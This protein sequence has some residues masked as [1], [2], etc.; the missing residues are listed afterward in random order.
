[1]N[2]KAI[3]FIVLTVS[4]AFILLL[5]SA[6]ILNKH[7]DKLL[8]MQVEVSQNLSLSKDVSLKLHNSFRSIYVNYD[9]LLAT[10]K[11][12]K[13]DIERI[14]RKNFNY[15]DIKN[16]HT[17]A[18]AQDDHIQMIKRTNSIITN[19]LQFLKH[20]HMSNPLYFTRIT[21]EL[22][23]LSYE[24]KL[25]DYSFL[26]FYAIKIKEFELLEVKRQ[27]LQVYRKKFLI[28]AKMIL[29]NTKILK[30]RLDSFNQHQ[31]LLESVYTNISTK[32]SQEN[33]SIKNKMKVIQSILVILL[34][35][36][37]FLISKFLK[38]E[39]NHKIEEEKLQKI[40]DKNVIMSIIDLQGITKTIS[41]AH[42]ELTG[43]EDNEL[44]NKPNYM[45]TH[46]PKAEEI[47]K[48]LESGRS[49]SG[50][51][52]D[53]K[54]NGEEYWVSSV[55][56]PIYDEHNKIK[57]YLGIRHDI[58]NT[59][60]LEKV[61]QN[62]ENIIKSQTQIANNERDKALKASQSKSEFLANMSHEIRTPLNTINGFIEL[63]QEDEKDIKKQDYL[64]IVKNSSHNLLSIINDIL[65]FSKIESGHLVIDTIDFDPKKEFDILVK[66]FEG[67]FLEKNIDF[68]I[69]FE[70]LPK[71]INGD[72]LRIQQVITN[73]L[74]NAYK[75]TSKNK[76]VYLRISYQNS[77]LNVMVR[78]E[79]VGI[80]TEYQKNIFE[81]F[82]QEDSSTTRKYGGT[83]LGLSISYNLALLMNGTLRV[84]SKI[85]EGS[86]FY[87]SVPLDSNNN[88]IEKEVIREKC[89][90]KGTVLLVE[91]NKANQMFMKVILKKFGLNFD[92]ANNGLE[93]VVMFK[94]RRYD[95]ILMDENMPNM[96]G[97]E[98]TQLIL[99]YEKSEKLVH[100]PIIALTANSLVGDK[101]RFLEAGMDEYLSKP[102]DKNTLQIFLEKYLEKK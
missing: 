97:L 17:I 91:D 39:K 96:S 66:T 46:S 22:L 68:I 12:F 43:Y 54:K 45:L 93:A 51:I 31:F 44:I 35:I 87:F 73:L 3:K 74:S 58:T 48:I 41:S 37:V 80:S 64:N 61:T 56:E 92:I 63:L 52:S 34:F 84:E 57:Y 23:D 7:A 6:I 83:G 88:Q 75:F 98:A 13:N 42:K 70:N 59:V 99:N 26:D 30:G 11:I 47:R 27:N 53:K 55:V 65:D 86:T 95:L 90:F 15:L 85:N 18:I 77:Y 1:M 8:S 24:I 2:T 40:I 50:Q 28:H 36:F 102:L 78:D 4:I 101:A 20:Y 14:T 94:E 60:R 100:T 29:K 49:W 72:I 69:S 5:F 33:H 81:T 25:S 38:L 79:G 19:S 67:K 89:L 71:T 21:Q 32:I 76:K 82:S 62:Q 9:Q 16:L 10:N